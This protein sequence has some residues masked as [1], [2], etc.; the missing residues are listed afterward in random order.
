MDCGSQFQ[1]PSQSQSSLDYRLGSVKEVE[2]E[3]ENQGEKDGEK[4]GEIPSP[5]MM[6]LHQQIKNETLDP[7]SR[8]EERDS[9]SRNFKPDAKYCFAEL[10]V[11]EIYPSVVDTSSRFLRK[12]AF[13]ENT[14]F[15][16]LPVKNEITEMRS[17]VTEEVEEEVVEEEVTPRS[18]AGIKRDNMKTVKYE[19][20]KFEKLLSAKTESEIVSS[21]S[22]ASDFMC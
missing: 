6:S 18:L 5:L 7:D 19:P 11:T 15:Q 16:L 4:Q 1:S 3:V 21:R 20:V 8:I 10:K 12:A 2:T 22:F 14:Q 13:R 9:Y 17:C